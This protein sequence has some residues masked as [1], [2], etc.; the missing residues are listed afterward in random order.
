MI[1]RKHLLLSIVFIVGVAWA[2]DTVQAAESPT[3]LAQKICSE[4]GFQGGFVVDLGCGAGQLTAALRTSDNIVVQGLDASLA[5][6]EKARAAIRSSGLY[7]P[8]SVNLLDGKRLP[9]VDNLAN[10]I[11]VE[12]GGQVPM[13]EIMRALAPLGVACVKKGGKWARIVKPWPTDIDEWPQHLY[14]ADNNAVAHDKVVGP[15]RYYQWTSTPEWSRAHLVLPSIQG[16]V[17]AKGR[18]FTI[19]D[20]A[21]IEHPALPGKFTLVA[22][23]A[24]N[25]IV[26]WQ[27]EFPDW[28]PMN[29]YIKHLTAQI[30]RRLA[31]I[32]ETVYCTPGYSAPIT[33]FDAATGKQLK[34]YDGTE[35]T[36]E[37]IYEQGVLY[38]VIG[39]HT[40]TRAIGDTKGSLAASQFPQ[41]AYGPIIPKLDDPK[42]TIV[43]IDADS[44]RR[45]WEKSG[46]D[47]AGYQGSTL[48]IRGRFVAFCSDKPGPD[49]AIQTTDRWYVSTGPRGTSCGAQSS[50]SPSVESPE[51][52]RLS[53]F[54]TVPFI[55][56]T[57]RLCMRYQ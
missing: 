25:G 49:P 37:L 38:A 45:L 5:N 8:V 1:D 32:G 52:P 4:T 34:T 43:A 18:L 6:V 44:G 35:R 48:A 3:A 16:L 47:T 54:P 11:V 33:T 17:S 55:W 41:A 57:P 56:P 50:S 9:Y 14:G 2:F 15:P 40:D 30:M 36:Q 31:V 22:R 46:A 13:S 19:E 20:Q 42:S 23:D 39:D 28:H 27:R 24:F 10:L 51:R 26:L 21:S 53:C 12:D 7:G 29:L